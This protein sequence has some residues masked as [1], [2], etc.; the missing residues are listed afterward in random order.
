M[1]PS[2]SMSCTL[3]AGVV[4]VATAVAFA[5]VQTILRRVDHAAKNAASPDATWWLGY[6]HDL[7]NLLLFIG[8]SAGFA[9]EGMPLPVACLAGGMAALIA[10]GLDA[11]LGR[12]PSFGRAGMILAAILVVL[13]IVEVIFA[14]DVESGLRRALGVLFS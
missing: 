9:V 3:A 1:L 7:S 11:W 12:S 6:A 14:E 13:A 4:L 8:F 10:H 5:A 2:G